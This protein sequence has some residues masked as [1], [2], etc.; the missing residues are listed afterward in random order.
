MTPIDFYNNINEFIKFNLKSKNVINELKSDLLKTSN[1]QFKRNEQQDEK[2]FKNICNVLL[3]KYV[4]NNN[5]ES[6]EILMELMNKLDF[7][8]NKTELIDLKLLNSLKNMKKTYNSLRDLNFI[9]DKLHDEY[10]DLN[11]DYINNF[12]RKNFNNI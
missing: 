1:W 8:D 6:I 11:I 10:T 3:N 12:V 5:K 4:K 7:L 2:I 9:I